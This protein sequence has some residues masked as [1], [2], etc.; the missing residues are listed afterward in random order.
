MRLALLEQTL[1]MKWDPDK[2]A[3]KFKVA[4]NFLD[5]N[6]ETVNYQNLSNEVRPVIPGKLTKRW[7]LAQLNRIYKSLG[8]I[9]PLTVKA[10]I[11]SKRLTLKERLDWDDGMPALLREEWIALFEDLLG[12]EEISFPRCIKPP[13]AKSPPSLVIFSDGPKEA[14]GAV[15][16]C[17]WETNDGYSSQLVA[18]KNK[19]APVK[20]VDIAGIMWRIIECT[21]E[22]IPREGIAFKY[23]KSTPHRRQ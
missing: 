3:F 16:Y 9:T 23:L 5:R 2:V 17:H 6:F 1:E 12:I 21:T 13:N 11:L 19:V 14:Y 10:K 15:A 22:G 8:L 7:V 20:I 4:L 18:S